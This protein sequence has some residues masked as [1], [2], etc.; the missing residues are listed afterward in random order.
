MDVHYSKHFKHILPISLHSLYTRDLE[1]SDKIIMPRSICKELVRAKFPFPPQLILVPQRPFNNSIYCTVLDFSAE[2]DHLYLPYWMLRELGYK[3]L[4]SNKTPKRSPKSGYGVTANSI[5]H[6]TNSSNL[7]YSIMKCRVIEYYSF[8][9]VNQEILQHELMKY[10]FIRQDSE[11][12]VLI[13]EQI[14]IIKILKV[15]PGPIAT[16]DGKFELLRI[17]N[18]PIKMKTVCEETSLME[19]F[20]SRLEKFPVFKKKL[21]KFLVEIIRKKESLKNDGVNE[22]NRLVKRKIYH[23]KMYSYEPIESQGTTHSNSSTPDLLKK[24]LK[25]NRKLLEVGKS[26]DDQ[27]N[28]LPPILN[29]PKKIKIN[30]PQLLTI[31]VPSLTPQFKHK[32]PS[33]SLKLSGWSKPRKNRSNTPYLSDLNKFDLSTSMSTYSYNEDYKY[34][35]GV[36]IL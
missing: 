27:I 13:N 6:N 15:I 31:A 32:T 18:V 10:M 8:T 29:V 2:E 24:S 14:I 34:I 22:T 12:S 1:F 30:S 5:G 36:K 26:M 28:V 19:N 4:N 3:V 20:K 35:K 16:T 25:V 7:C 9:E 33:H 23:K 11:V 21:P 17:E